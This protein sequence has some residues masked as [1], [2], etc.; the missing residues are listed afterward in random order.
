MFDT[1]GKDLARWLPD[2]AET[3]SSSRLRAL[4]RGLAS[5]G[6][7]AVL[8]YRIFRWARTHHLPTQ[9]FRYLVERWVEITTGVSIPAE[10]EFGPGLRIHHFGSIIV[11]PHVQAGAGCT[12]YHNVTLGTDGLSEKAPRLGNDVLV[13]AGA[14]VLGDVE[15]GDRCRIGANAVVT[16][17][18]PPDSV[19][20]GVPARVVRTAAGHKRLAGEPTPVHGHSH[21]GAADD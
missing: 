9:P 19:L 20:V 17:S 2:R 5:P 8:T 18:A 4:V 1:I 10:A 11:H 13:G 12:L 7:Q 21:R 3:N 14:K 6:F 16:R 15:I